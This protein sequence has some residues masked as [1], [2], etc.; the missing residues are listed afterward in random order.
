MTSPSVTKIFRPEVDNRGRTWYV[1]ECP[2]IPGCVVY[3]DVESEVARLLDH[4]IEI[5]LRGAAAHAPKQGGSEARIGFLLVH[6]PQPTAVPYAQWT[7][8]AG[9]SAPR[10]EESVT[11]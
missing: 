2:E 3:S 4:A 10:D 6:C 5:A 1:G 7:E 11:V 8:N 9:K